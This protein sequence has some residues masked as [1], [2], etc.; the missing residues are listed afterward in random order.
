[1]SKQRTHNYSS[2]GWG[3]RVIMGKKLDIRG[4][5]WRVSGFGHGV[6]KGDFLILPNE[7]ETTRYQVDEIDYYLDPKDM[8]H[9]VISFAP[10]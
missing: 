10:R 8:W 2:P 5:R 3:H 1:M 7:S 6:R 4:L 9:G